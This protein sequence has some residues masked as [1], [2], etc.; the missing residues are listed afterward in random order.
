[1]ALAEHPYVAEIASET[2]KVKPEADDK[3]RRYGETH[4]VRLDVLTHRFRLVEERCEAYAL[5]VTG[6]EILDQ[7]GMVLPVSMMSSTTMTLRPEMSSVRPAISLTLPLVDV[8][9]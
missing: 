7:L 9:S 1:M 4:V 5:G 3:R 6:L 8:P 2:V